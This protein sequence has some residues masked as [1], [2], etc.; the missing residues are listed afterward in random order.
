MGIPQTV[1]KKNRQPPPSHP[2]SSSKSSKSSKPKKSF[3]PFDPLSIGTIEDDD[4]VQVFDPEESEDEQANVS[5]EASN[6]ADQDGGEEDD[7]DDDD[8]EGQESAGVKPNM[9]KAEKK[10]AK[11]KAREDKKQEKNQRKQQQQQQPQTKT[12]TA[13]TTPSSKSN[14]SNKAN[15]KSKADDP[16]AL[17]LNPE[18][19]FEADGGDAL[20]IGVSHPWDFTAAKASLRKS[21]ALLNDIKTDKDAAG[22]SVEPGAGIAELS[23]ID[24]KIERKRKE[25]E[26]AKKNGGIKK[27]KKVEEE[28]EEDEENEED[29]EESDSGDFVGADDDDEDSDGIVALIFECLVNITC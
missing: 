10:A 14:N 1:I 24:D 8:D 21:Q 25:M 5:I 3:I 19:T 16:E 7:N 13:I 12:H 22:S 26:A 15:A 9:T 27:R 17:Q 29:G 20:S 28:V 11:K 18:F 4:E 23:S 6:G 2:S